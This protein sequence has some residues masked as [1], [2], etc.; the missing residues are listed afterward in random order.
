MD[1]LTLIS[2]FVFFGP[3]QAS[4]AAWL[5]DVGTQLVVQDPLSGSLG[6][7]FSN[8]SSLSSLFINH[9]VDIITDNDPK[10]DTSLAGV[11]W[12]DGGMTWVFL[13]VHHSP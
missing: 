4:M 6:Y 1:I 8:G 12:H 10:N 9:P 7:I 3:A 5:I 13:P 2:F 11:G